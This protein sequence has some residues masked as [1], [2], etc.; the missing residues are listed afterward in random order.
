VHTLGLPVPPAI[1]TNYAELN[2]RD[3]YGWLGDTNS[4]PDAWTIDISYEG[5]LLE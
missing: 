3:A 5:N 4:N 2:L 1:R